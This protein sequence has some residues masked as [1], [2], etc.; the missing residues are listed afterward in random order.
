MYRALLPRSATTL[1]DAS[2]LDHLPLAMQPAPVWQPAAAVVQT[3]GRWQH[4]SQE[5][6]DSGSCTGDNS[7]YAPLTTLRPPPLPASINTFDSE[8]HR[9]GVPPLAEATTFQTPAQLLSELQFQQQASPL[10]GRQIKKSRT[11][12]SDLD[13]TLVHD[14]FGINMTAP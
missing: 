5:Y 10:E 13:M 3:P 9:H 1:G 7:G 8:N 12:Q 6:V 14:L 4:L 2:I 11:K